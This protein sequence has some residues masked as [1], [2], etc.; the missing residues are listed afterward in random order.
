[1]EELGFLNPLT[2]E[3]KIN[4]ERAKYWVSVGAKPS[5]T[6]YNLLIKEKAL[7]GKKISVHKAKKGGQEAAM[8]VAPK[9]GTVAA[10]EAVAPAVA[11][12]N[13]PEGKKEEAKPE[14][15]K[16]EQKT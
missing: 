5:P 1:M 11:P 6:I 8:P 15:V 10:P 7:T 16:T 2:K 12:E 9:A 13:K 3:K 14:E 4:G